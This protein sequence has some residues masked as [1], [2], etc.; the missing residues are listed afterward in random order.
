MGKRGRGVGTHT[1]RS[2]S[3]L[4]HPCPVLCGAARGENLGGVGGER[5]APRGHPRD[6]GGA[7]KSE[8]EWGGGCVRGP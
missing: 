4:Q 1:H 3:Y 8:M 6:K 2:C 7:A 5:P